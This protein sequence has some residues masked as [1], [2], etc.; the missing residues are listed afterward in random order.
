MAVF[1]F[2]CLLVA[3]DWVFWCLCTERATVSFV[4]QTNRAD[5][6]RAHVWQSWSRTFAHAQKNEPTQKPEHHC[7]DLTKNPCIKKCLFL[8]KN[9]AHSCQTQHII[10][11]TLAASVACDAEPTVNSSRAHRQQTTTTTF[12]FIS[13][14]KEPEAPRTHLLTSKVM[15]FARWT[16]ALKRRK[17]QTTGDHTIFNATG[18]SWVP[19]WRQLRTLCRSWLAEMYFLFTMILLPPSDAAVL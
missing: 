17:L 14:H 4:K 18:R 1:R 16:G 19:G 15:M 9:W 8:K 3:N 13:R 10:V 11:I 12:H 6:N 5:C 2:H 7:G